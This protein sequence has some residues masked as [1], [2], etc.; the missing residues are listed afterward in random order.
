MQKR[1]RVRNAA[2]AR[3]GIV[4]ILLEGFGEL[5]EVARGFHG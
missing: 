2:T 1:Q 5:G 4:A 3:S